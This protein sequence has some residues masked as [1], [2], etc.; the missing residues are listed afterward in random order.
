MHTDKNSLG[1]EE[2]IE[3]CPPR[4]KERPYESDILPEGALTFEGLKPENLFNGYYQYYFNRIDEN[5][6]SAIERD[7]EEQQ[8]R[9]FKRGEEQILKDMDEFDWSVGDIPESKDVFKKTKKD[10]VKVEVKPAIEKLAV[11]TT[12]KQPSTIAARKAASALAMPKSSLRPSGFKPSKS[13]KTVIPPRTQPRSFILP[14]RPAL[15]PATTNSVRQRTAL[16][17]ASRNT[18]GYSKGRSASSVVRGYK[19]PHTARVPEPAPKTRE[20]SRS[21]STASKGSDATITPA[22]FAKESVEWK[23]PDFLSIFDA[24]DA[25]EDDADLGGVPPIEDD[26]ETFQFATDF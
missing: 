26:E 8:Q 6:K 16:G 11:G 18:L 15:L 9:N 4:P 20:L 14:K 23:N 25:E 12:S 2:E 22:R 5:G 24:D 10:T 19:D 7:M 3:Y 13:V 1:E 21:G 17:F